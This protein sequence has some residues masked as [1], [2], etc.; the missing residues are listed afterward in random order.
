MKPKGVVYLVGA[1]PGDPDLLTVKA[2]RLIQ[3]AD[4]VVY[5]R[6]VSS[7][8]MDLIPPGISRIAVG[9]APGLHCVPQQEINELLA[10]LARKSRSIVRLKGGD[11]FVFGRGSEEALLLDQLGI[12]FEVVPGITAASAVST[13]AGIPLTHRSM[14]RGVRLVT[15]HLQEGDAL[16]LDWQ[17]LADP[18]ATLVVYMGLS[19]LST[20][21]QGLIA[22]GRES[23]TPAAAIQDGTTPRQRRVIATLGTLDQA[24]RNNGLRSPVIIIVG[25]TVALADRLD[26]FEPEEGRDEAHCLDRP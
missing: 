8:I 1:G 3:T 2:L 23:S 9:K 4:V 18:T 6:L 5:D 7:E 19:N 10:S 11:P 21:T 26:W 24:V 14:S 22:A 20:I 25:E 17:K 15:G 16:K 12:P 13:Y